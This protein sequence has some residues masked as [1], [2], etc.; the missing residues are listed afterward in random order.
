MSVSYLKFETPPQFARMTNLAFGNF[1]QRFCD[2]IPEDEEEPVEDGPQ[3]QMEGL[4]AAVGASSI[5]VSPELLEKLKDALARL[6]RLTN[7]SRS[8]VETASL[9]EVDAARIEAITFALNHIENLTKSPIPTMKDAAIHLYNKSKAYKGAGLLSV[10]DRTQAIVGFLEDMGRTEFSEYITTLAFQPTLDALRE[11]NDRYSQLVREREE[12]VKALEK[13]GNTKAVRAE[14]EDL[15]E[16]ITDRAFATN[17]L[18]SSPE[19][20]DFIETINVRIKDAKKRLKWEAS[21]KDEEEMPDT[22]TPDTETPGTETPSIDDPSTEEPGTETP[23]IEEPDT[24]DPNEPS[25]EEPDDR[26]VVQ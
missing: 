17:L 19:A 2:D 6:R 25:T 7:E 4:R 13:L 1:M 5:S 10:N 3:V 26:P 24:E 14:L 12:G 22:E 20:T 8:N 21:H 11:L 18:N 9:D 16:E 23:D 15:Y